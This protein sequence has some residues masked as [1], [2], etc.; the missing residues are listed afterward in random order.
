MLTVLK[1]SALFLT[2][3]TA[4]P[5]LAHLFELPNKIGLPR[6]EYSVVQ[7]AY[8][9]WNQLAYILLV[10]LVSIVALA[11]AALVAVALT[12]VGDRLGIDLYLV[13]LFADVIAPYDPDEPGVSAQAHSAAIDQFRVTLEAARQRRRQSSRE[14][15]GAA[16]RDA[17]RQFIMVP[18]HRPSTMIRSSISWRVYIATVP[19]ATWRATLRQTEPISRSRLRTPAS[20]VYSVTM[21]LT[22]PSVI[23]RC[24]SRPCCHRS[25]GRARCMRWS[26]PASGSCRCSRSATGGTSAACRW[27]STP[28]RGSRRSSSTTATPA[29][30]VSPSWP[31]TPPIATWPPPTTSWPPA[32]ARPAARRASSPRSAGTGTSTSTSG[33]PSP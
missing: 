7:Q 4:A 21:R 30:P 5:G 12:F 24:S 32:P 11:V 10:E 27:P 25:G 33:P 14:P 13:A 1:I 18:R 6:D 8:R 31:S 19:S 9:G 2:M 16:G 29:A 15:P 22:A 28:P 20:R 3:L 23:L 26:T 17:Y